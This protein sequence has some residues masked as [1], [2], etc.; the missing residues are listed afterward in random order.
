MA[1]WAS[2][3][4]T[5]AEIRESEFWTF[6]GVHE[7]GEPL[8]ADD[9]PGERTVRLRTGGFQEHVEL[10]AVCRPDDRVGFGRLRLRETW[11]FGPP[12][13]VNPHAL[14]L[15]RSFLQT[16]A[17]DVD[18][19]AVLQLAPPLTPPEAASLLS[20][21]P[22]MRRP[23]SMFLVA[24]AGGIPGLKLELTKSELWVTRPEAGW[25]QIGVTAF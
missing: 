9:R 17:P 2:G 5:Y 4:R 8:A 6:F 24:L 15:V 10:E 7:S 22:D 13:G 11:A 1:E 19:A 18:Q 21:P 14:D 23:A 12:W 25:V 3:A 20:R 16:F